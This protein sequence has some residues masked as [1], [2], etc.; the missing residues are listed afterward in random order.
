MYILDV[1][2]TKFTRPLVVSLLRGKQMYG[3]I[4][5]II[6]EIK[7]K[8]NISYRFFI[9]QFVIVSESAFFKNLHNEMFR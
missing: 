3:S 4:V 1:I 9:A 5:I 6:V 8:I 7:N 2:L